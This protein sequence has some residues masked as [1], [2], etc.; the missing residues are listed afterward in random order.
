MTDASPPLRTPFDE[1]TTAEEVLA[2]V[3]LSGRRS[4]REPKATAGTASPPTP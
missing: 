2:D 3:D 4:P 1:H